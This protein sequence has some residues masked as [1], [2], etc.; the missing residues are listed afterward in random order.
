MSEVGTKDA[1]V[2]STVEDAYAK[3]AARYNG[4]RGRVFAFDGGEDMANAMRLIDDLAKVDGVEIVDWSKKAPETFNNVAIVRNDGTDD[5]PGDGNPRIIAF[6]PIDVALADKVVRENLYRMYVNRVL[7]KARLATATEDEFVTPAGV[8]RA[9]QSDDC[10]KFQSSALV[11]LMRRGGLTNV[12]SG[13]LKEAFSNQA[14]AV[15]M[16][17]TVKPEMW[18][19]IINVA[20]ANAEKHGYDTAWFTLA[21]ATRDVKKNTSEAFELDLGAFGT[22]LATKVDA[23]LASSGAA[24]PVEAQA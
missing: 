16:F 10:F 6:A 24:D 2:N 13:S 1:T 3:F 11:T 19:N 7:G 12:T 15:T 8:Y 9:T 5:E 21:L 23:K 17:P 20:M 22:D 4:K 14:F 18:N